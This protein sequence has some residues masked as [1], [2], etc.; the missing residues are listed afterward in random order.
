M[1]PKVRLAVRFIQANLH[2]QITV[3]EICKATGLKHSRL[4]GS[5]HAE[6][7]MSPLQYHKLQRLNRA[8]E[9]LEYTPDKVEVIILELGYD[10]RS[11]FRDFQARFGVTPSQF[12]ARHIKA[13]PGRE[14]PGRKIIGES[15]TKSELLALLFS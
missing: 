13:S 2:R 6:Y 10:R 1:N 11:F 9:L 12:R 15:V 8:R 5:F 3:D 14:S 7:G 4:C